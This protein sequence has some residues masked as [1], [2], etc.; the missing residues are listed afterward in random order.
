MTLIRTC[1]D[2]KPGSRSASAFHVSRTPFILPPLSSQSDL[3]HARGKFDLNRE[4]HKNAIRSLDR[5]TQRPRI[6]NAELKFRI[7]IA[8]TGNFERTLPA[9]DNAHVFP[10][11]VVPRTTAKPLHHDTAGRML[12]TSQPRRSGEDIIHHMPKCATSSS[13]VSP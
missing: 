13:S 1:S 5:Q 9:V 7:L 12:R 3:M 11:Q 6:V 4:R 10:N 8:C 2:L